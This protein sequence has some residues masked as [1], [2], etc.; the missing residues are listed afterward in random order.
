MFK[1]RLVIIFMK[2]LEATKNKTQYFW[3][4]GQE[5]RYA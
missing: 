2:I 4:P 1:L 5:L 3:K